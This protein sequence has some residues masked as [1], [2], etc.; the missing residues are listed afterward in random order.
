MEHKLN[1]EIVNDTPFPQLSYILALDHNAVKTTQ[2]EAVLHKEIQSETREI[3][4]KLRKKDLWRIKSASNRF[5]LFLDVLDICFGSLSDSEHLPFSLEYKA[6]VDCEN[7]KKILL[8]SRLLHVDKSSVDLWSKYSTAQYVF[9]SLLLFFIVL[10]ASV[11]FSGIFKAL[12]LGGFAALIALLF[13]SLVRRRNR[14][15]KDLLE[16]AEEEVEEAEETQR[17]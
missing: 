10:L 6:H 1:L 5:W 12:W 4:V 14:L 17:S 3:S 13:V 15:K 8:L 2:R 9:I 11:A 7:D 16:L